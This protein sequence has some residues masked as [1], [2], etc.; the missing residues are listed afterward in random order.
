[1]PS[2][3]SLAAATWSLIQPAECVGRLLLVHAPHAHALAR[4][5]LQGLSPVPLQEFTRQR[6]VMVT[7]ERGLLHAL[8]FDFTVELPLPLAWRFLNT[9]D[10]ENEWPCNVANPQAHAPSQI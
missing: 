4:C 7:A 8:A 10:G 1:M 9:L 5:T 2:S 3:R 6:E